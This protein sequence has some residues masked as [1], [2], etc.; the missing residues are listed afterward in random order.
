[1]IIEDIL[2]YEALISIKNHI[3]IFTKFRK[4]FKLS[5]KTE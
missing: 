5:K 3:N 1:M 2:N 4:N